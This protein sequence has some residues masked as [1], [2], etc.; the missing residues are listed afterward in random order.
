MDASSPLLKGVANT[1]PDAAALD[2]FKADILAGRLAQV[3][4]LIAPEAYCE[5][6]D[7]SAR[8]RAA[9]TCRKY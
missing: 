8:C 2:T 3:S 1:M 5:H 9:G 6:P 4:W 7:P